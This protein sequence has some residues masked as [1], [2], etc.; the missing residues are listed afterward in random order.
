MPE[1]SATNGGGARPDNEED[2]VVD[3]YETQSTKEMGYEEHKSRTLVLLS[4][5]KL[6]TELTR[7][8]LPVF[9]CENRSLLQVIADAFRQ[10]ELLLK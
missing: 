4:Q 2:Y 5:L 10:P 9:F 1:G 3:E 7:T 8:N 6:G